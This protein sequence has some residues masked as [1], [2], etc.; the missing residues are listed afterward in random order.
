MNDMLKAMLERRSVRTYTGE[1]IPDEKMDLIV[2]A[3]LSSASSRNLREWEFYVVRDK[4]ML[5]KLSG[6]RTAGAAM[7]KNAD[8]CIVVLGDAEKADTWIED[9]SIALTNMH[10]MADSVGVGSCWIQGRNRFATEE[11]TT[12]GYIKE[13]LGF[14]DN[15]KL[16][17]LLSLGM[18]ENKA[19]AHTESELLMDKVKYIG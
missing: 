13:L 15:L 5:L 17:A 14:G 1:R 19:S 9:C 11:Q 8:A 18:P 10:L 16:C 7:L 3:G 2:K 12:E 6:S 4:D